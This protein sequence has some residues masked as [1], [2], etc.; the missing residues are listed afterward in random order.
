MDANVALS[1][2]A[3]EFI[4]VLCNEDGTYSNCQLIAQGDEFARYVGLG[5]GAGLVQSRG[6]MSVFTKL[7]PKP[8]QPRDDDGS[9]S[10]EEREFE[11]LMQKIERLQNLGVV[12]FQEEKK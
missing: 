7:S 6:L 11:Q 4:F 2:Y 3:G 10:E 1:Y 12:K 8:A 5:P 9:D